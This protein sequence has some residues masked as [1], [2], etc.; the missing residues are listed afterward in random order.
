MPEMPAAREHHRQAALVG[1]GDHLR[2]THRSA[3]L[4]DRRGAGVGQ[5]VEAVAERK[6]RVGRGNADPAERPRAA[7]IT[8]TFTRVDTAH[9]AGADRERAIGDR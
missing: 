8:A 9:L 6:E 1:R 3:R 4:H 7:F 5:R 2:I